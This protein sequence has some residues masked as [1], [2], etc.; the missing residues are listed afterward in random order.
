MQEIWVQSL[1][2]E[3]PL[4]KEM[5]THSSI[6]AWRILWTEEPGG[7]QSMRSQRGG[8]D[9]VT[10]AHTQFWYKWSLNHVLTNTIKNTAFH[11]AVKGLYS[12]SYGF[13]NSHVW[14]WELDQKESWAPTNWCFQIAVLKKTLES[15]LDSKEIK[16]VSPKGNQPWIFIG[17][18]DTEAEA[19]ILWLPDVKSQLFGKDCDAR[20]D[21]RQE[22]GM[23]ENEMVGWHHW[24]NGRDFE[25]APGDSK[26]QGSLVCCSPWG[27]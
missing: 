5:A 14:L 1:G 9:W 8:H 4:E 15:P 17:R 26:G 24:L 11:F 10:N 12:Q 2:W 13:P 25:K 6:L 16:P 23:T 22:K 21:W 7:L 18:A 3:D 20:K 19:P 27:R